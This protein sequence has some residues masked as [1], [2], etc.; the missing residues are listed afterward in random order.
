MGLDSGFG[1]FPA[2]SGD[3]FSRRIRIC[4]PKCQISASRGLNIGKTN[5]EDFKK[6]PYPH[7][8][9][10]KQ[11]DLKQYVWSQRGLDSGFGSFP[12]SSGDDFSRRIRFCGRECW[13]SASRGLNI[14]FH[15][16][17]KIM[18]SSLFYVYWFALFKPY[19]HVN[20]R[21]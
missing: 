13:I 18:F 1:S 10:N 17:I 5:L 4:G 20:P 16:L 19:E 3:D 14:R 15:Y 6:S 2:G 8:V 11:S 7:D 21:K 9:I 12:A